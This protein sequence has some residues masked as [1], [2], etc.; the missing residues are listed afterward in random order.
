MHL[1]DSLYRVRS[2]QE[3]LPH[4]LRAGMGWTY[5]RLPRR[6]TLGPAFERFRAEA[7]QV[8]SW[9]ADEI[10]AYQLDQVR[11]VL[12]RA[13]AHSP[14]YARRFA[15]AGFDP[16]SVHDLAD[17]DGCP[18][19]TKRDLADHAGEM[20]AD[21][22]PPGRR[23]Y[24][25]TGG[26]TGTPVGFYLTKGLSRPKEQAYL[27]AQWRRAGWFDGARLAVVRGQVT[28]ARAGGRI[29]T[30]DPARD[31]LL[32][33]S[34]HLT[35]ARLDEYL[36]AIARFR[37][38]VLHIY[39][40]AALLLVAHMRSAGTRFPVPLCCVLAASERLTGPQRRVLEEAFG[41]RVYSWYGHA[42]RV[43]L[44]GQGQRSDLFY[45]WPTY[46]YVEL[47]PPD[48][49]G[50]REVVGT[51]FHNPAMPLVRYRTGDYVR[52]HDPARDG[53]AELPWPAVQAIEGRDQELLV[54]ATGRRISLTALNMHDASFDG[55]YAVQFFQ[56]T[57]G[58][59]EL[60]YVAGPSF[61]PSRL[62]V[63]ESAVRSKLG[64][65]L[66]VVLRQVDDIEKTGQGKG[67]WL[68]SRLPQATAGGAGPG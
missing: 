53:E 10:A 7:E 21:D 46:G 35:E 14:F 28:S 3:R 49:Q 37:P 23:L 42:E 9:S 4:R 34:Y 50:L 39:P 38:D 65:D 36:E 11:S 48:A 33:S 20:V 6:L 22:V 19:V 15:E 18:Y 52:P 66:E 58:R 55:L 64:D 40:S 12:A 57:E 61:E 16:R 60:R 29:A 56:D 44:A 31:W 63:I 1:E 62:P 54:S 24:V 5:R 41:C 59:A 13:A 27:E 51:G 25:T 17:L 67:R 32:L 30:Y 26:S 2:L 45:F 43:V 68:V 47:G 8:A